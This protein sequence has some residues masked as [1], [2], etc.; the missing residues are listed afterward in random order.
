MKRLTNAQLEARFEA[1]TE[2]AGHLRL[3]WTD[4]KLEWE[5]G[6]K[7]AAWLDREAEKCLDRR[8]L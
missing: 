8:T 1:L 6:K 5:E 2:A 4:D 7:I 3:D